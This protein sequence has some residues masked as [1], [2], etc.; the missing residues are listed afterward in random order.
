[1]WVR[2]TTCQIRLQTSDFIPI[3]VVHIAAPHG[4][5]VSE[6]AVIPYSM[7]TMIHIKATHEDM[8]SE[9]R[10]SLASCRPWYIS[11]QTLHTWF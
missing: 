2:N 7:L 11:S 4:D 1:M 9:L 10:R 6:A 5:M 3:P 8:V